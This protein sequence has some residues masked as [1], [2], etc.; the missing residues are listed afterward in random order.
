MESSIL[1]FKRV[2]GLYSEQLVNVYKSY[3]LSQ[4]ISK[5]GVAPSR[6]SLTRKVK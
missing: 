6:V 4:L 2:K 5:V 3:N 1:L